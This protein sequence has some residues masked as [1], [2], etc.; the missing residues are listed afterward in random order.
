MLWHKDLL[1]F[2]N[3]DFFMAISEID[4]SNGPFIFLKKRTHQEF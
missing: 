2:K 4:E 1:G 3:L